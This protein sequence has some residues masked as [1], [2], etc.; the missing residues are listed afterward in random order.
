MSTIVFMGQK[1][2]EKRLISEQTYKYHPDTEMKEQIIQDLKKHLSCS[3]ERYIIDLNIQVILK[4]YDSKN[5]PPDKN[6]C[7]QESLST[8]T[9]V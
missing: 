4:E 1:V 2:P 5:Q 8:K 6:Q 7:Y 3:L 9:D